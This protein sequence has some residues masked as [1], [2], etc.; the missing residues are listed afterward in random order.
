[1]K[2]A[3]WRRRL[4]SRSNNEPTLT[5]IN[6]ASSRE[7]SVRSSG[8]DTR[9]VKLNVFGFQQ[10]ERFRYVYN[11]FASWQCD[12]NELAKR[13]DQLQPGMS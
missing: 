4:Y 1:M 3:A 6:C 5:S 12:I 10:G 13:I 8:G 7:A 2:R 11:F 9:H